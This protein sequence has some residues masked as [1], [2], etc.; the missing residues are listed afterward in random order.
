MYS[1]LAVQRRGA[2]IEPDHQPPARITVSVFS[3]IAILTSSV[4]P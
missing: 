2:S 4:S 3:L 1:R